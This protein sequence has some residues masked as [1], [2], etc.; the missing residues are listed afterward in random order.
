MA[1]DAEPVG[2]GVTGTR[3]PGFVVTSLTPGDQ[4][5]LAAAMLICLLAADGENV[6]AMVPVETGIDE[7]CE[8]GSRGAL[9]RWAAGHLDDPRMVTPF[10][11]AAARSAMHAADVEGTLLHAAAFE[12]ARTVLSEGRSRF[13]VCDA[14]GL[15]DLIT[16]TLTTLDLAQR[17]QL[18]GVA[19]EPVSRWSV[20]HVKLLE[21]AMLSRE[22]LVTGV[23][24]TGNELLPD[25][26]PDFID[27]I[28]E[29]L[30][31]ELDCPVIVM[32]PVQTVHDRGDLLTAARACGLQ[33]LLARVSP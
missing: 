8:P 29:T 33:R 23:I 25:V 30:A 7:P 10:A 13:V 32:P 4:T 20:G 9:V 2:S 19:V 22:M 28:R 15:L 11:L 16:P 18:S 12:R 21:T 26:E 3:L 14:I 5:A 6:A 24:L 31:A 17:W 27:R 1:T